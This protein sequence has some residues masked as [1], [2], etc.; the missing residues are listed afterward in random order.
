MLEAIA[1]AA[2]LGEIVL[3]P[4]RMRLL[5]GRVRGELAKVLL[6]R[7][8]FT[9]E[10]IDAP[11]QFERALA[12]GLALRGEH[13]DL[14][15]ACGA[16]RLARCGDPAPREHEDEEPAGDEPCGGRDK[17]ENDRRQVRH[18]GTSAFRR[19]HCDSADSQLT[20]F[21]GRSQRSGL[22]KR[23]RRAVRTAR[24]RGKNMRGSDQAFGLY[25]EHQ[26]FAAVALPG[27]RL[28]GPNASPAL[29]VQNLQFSHIEPGL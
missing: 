22:H 13:G 29:P 8:P 4:L 23:R 24:R 17:H 19:R 28:H 26:P 3:E 6:G 27:N 20:R 21:D 10:A 25:P 11:L 7:G 14:A 1:A 18:R 16:T 12:F 9:L 15:V 2:R 5:R